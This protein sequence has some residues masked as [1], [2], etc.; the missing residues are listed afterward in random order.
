MTR[1]SGGNDGID[2]LKGEAAPPEG[3]S[4]LNL[5]LDIRI[6]PD[7]IA[8]GDQRPPAYR[9]IATGRRDGGRL[10]RNW[11]IGAPKVGGDSQPKI[12]G[13]ETN[14]GRV[15]LAAAGSRRG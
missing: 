10:R 9:Q 5:V 14:R 8:E 15:A 13:K 1:S 7:H 2:E 4:S 11:R 6:P 3:H 12:S